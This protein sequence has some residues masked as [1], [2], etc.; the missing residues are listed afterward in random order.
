MN[1]HSNRHTSEEVQVAFKVLMTHV[2]CN[3]HDVSHFAA[4]FIVVG[5][6]TSVAE[7]VDLVISSSSGEGSA[8]KQTPAFGIWIVLDQDELFFRRAEKSKIGFKK[9]FGSEP[10]QQVHWTFWAKSCGGLASVRGTKK[11]GWPR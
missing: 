9:G 5:A 8:V 3:S 4:F 2:F 7:S 1:R 10:A 11:R 6:K